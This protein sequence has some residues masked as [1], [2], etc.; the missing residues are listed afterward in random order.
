MFSRQDHAIFVELQRDGRVPFTTLA[1]RLG[2]SEAQ[3]R[4]RVRALT[5]LDMFAVT[6]VA[7]PRLLGLD[8][9]AW[10]GF[11]VHPAAV[12]ALAEQ[13]VNMSSVAYVVVSSGRFNV[14]ADLACTSNAELDRILLELRRLPGVQRTETFIYLALAR[15]QFQWLSSDEASRLLDNGAAGVTGG[16]RELDPL[17]ISIIRELEHDGRASF[18][19]VGRRLGVSER[20]VSTRFAVLVDQN[21]LKVMAVGNPRNLG[22]DALAWLGITLSTG[23]DR[24]QIVSALGRIPAIHYIVVPSGRYDLMAEVVCRD[25]DELMATLTDEV[26]AIDGIAGV[27][28]FF[29]LQ[30]LY[31]SSAAAWGVGR[32]RTTERSVRGTLSHGGN[33]KPKAAGRTRR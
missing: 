4:R 23:S 16:P 13:L 28:T 17:D 27:E 22:F 26:G 3:V 20:V 12:R 21:V 8:C 30:I 9:L 10:I 6:A 18:R 25:R 14:M 24:D 2:I 32:K 1:D 5:E 31:S 19:D 7:D 33:E 11:V 15:Q 29:Y